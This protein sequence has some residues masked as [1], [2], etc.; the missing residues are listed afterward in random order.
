[1]TPEHDTVLVVDF[2]A[3]YAQLIARRV[4]EA[5]VYSEIVPRTISAAELVARR[6]RGIIFSGGPASVHVDGSPGIDAA[7]Y[8]TDVPILGICYGA[9]LLARDCGGTVRETGGGEYGRTPL[10]RTEAGSVLLADTPAEQTVWM[11]HGD[12]IASAPT[13]A[14][15]TATSP[16]ATI[17]AVSSATRVAASTAG[18]R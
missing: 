2:G 15:A 8:G 14:V 9:Q 4:R 13:G 18:P 11:S 1:M 6:P 16:G 12:A 17:A 5:R 10:T 3:Q 7:V